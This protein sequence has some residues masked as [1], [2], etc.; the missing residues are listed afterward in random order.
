ML[1][2]LQWYN[3]SWAFFNTCNQHHFTRSLR[4]Y[5]CVLATVSQQAHFGKVSLTCCSASTQVHQKFQTLVFGTIKIWTTNI[6]I[7]LDLKKQE[8]QLWHQKCS[9]LSQCS[10][11]FH[12]FHI[13]L[14]LLVVV[15]E[16]PFHHFKRWYSLLLCLS[17]I[18]NGML[19]SRGQSLLL[20]KNPR[21]AQ[22]CGDLGGAQKK[23]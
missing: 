1:H 16:W 10:R 9:P 17:T 22:K 23:M 20:E 2:L 5:P 12:N 6:Y 21:I 4:R 3:V 19:I 18:S 13:W 7:H 15:P 11:K 14:Q 8:M